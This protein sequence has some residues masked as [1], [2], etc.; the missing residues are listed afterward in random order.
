MRNPTTSPMVR[1]GLQH[2]KWDGVCEE[3]GSPRREGATAVLATQ[4]LQWHDGAEDVE[5][6]SLPRK[7]AG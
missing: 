3:G 1:L 4:A 5:S 2:V 7:D 6:A